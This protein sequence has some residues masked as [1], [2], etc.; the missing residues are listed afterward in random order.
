MTEYQEKLNALIRKLK[1]L[2]TVVE[3]I[4][5]DVINEDF[6]SMVKGQLEKGQDGKGQEIGE[7]YSQSWADV[8]S[9]KG[10]QTTF[11]DLIFSG[12]LVNTFETVETA[13]DWYLTSSATYLDDLIE[14]YGIEI[15]GIQDKNLKEIKKRI[16]IETVKEF[17]DG[18]KD[19]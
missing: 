19:K 11:V 15:I 16:I 14:R 1:D 17:K 3:L 13:D 2:P 18:G 10:L 4:A 9:S 8:R 5:D 12:A 7:G 6:P